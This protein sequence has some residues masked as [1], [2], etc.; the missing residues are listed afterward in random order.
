MTEDEAEEEGENFLD[1]SRVYYYF[2]FFFTLSTV[3]A[4]RSLSVLPFYLAPIRLPSVPPFRNLVISLCLSLT[5][6]VSLSLS[7]PLLA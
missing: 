1:A 3:V 7:Q 2:S 6:S 5:L 4:L